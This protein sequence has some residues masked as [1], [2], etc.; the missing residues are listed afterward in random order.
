MRLGILGGVFNPPHIGHLVC[1][2]EAHE[3]LGLDRLLLVPVG[4]APHRTVVDDPGGLVR[5]ELCERAVDG[6]PRFEVSRMEVERVGPS[7][8]LDTLRALRG[9]SD[10][11]GL[12]LVLGGDQAASLPRWHEPEEVLALA[13]VAVAE[14][15][16]ARREQVR[17]AVAALRG[18]ERVGFF[19]M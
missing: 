8:T 4:E 14:R 7:Y 15:G 2:Q 6:D 5:A 10:D 19:E 1:A 12:V 9:R 11:D 3:Q 13:V 16:D 18:G 17:S